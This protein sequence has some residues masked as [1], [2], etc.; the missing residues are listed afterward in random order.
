M[1]ISYNIELKIAEM[2][3]KT[4]TILICES[5]FFFF[6]T[7]GTSAIIY[8]TQIFLRQNYYQNYYLVT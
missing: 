5:K 3:M 6:N 2:L 1:K 7:L 8:N 4:N